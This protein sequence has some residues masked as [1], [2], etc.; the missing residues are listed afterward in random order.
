MNEW[1]VLFGILPV[2]VIG[3]AIRYQIRASFVAL[4]NRPHRDVAMYAVLEGLQSS[5]GVCRSTAS[6]TGK[7]TRRHPAICAESGGTAS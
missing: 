6:G 7:G 5:C 4:V 1:F 3:Y 2:N